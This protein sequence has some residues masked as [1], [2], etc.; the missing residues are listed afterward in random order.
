[1]LKLCRLCVWSPASVWCLPDGFAT[2][3][4]E[5]WTSPHVGDFKRGEETSPPHP[6]AHWG[7]D[8][9]CQTTYHWIQVTVLKWKKLL[10]NKT[11]SGVKCLRLL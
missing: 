7:R 3:W 11:L 5:A 6:Q 10:F 8:H 9:Y 4:G 2:R 1:M